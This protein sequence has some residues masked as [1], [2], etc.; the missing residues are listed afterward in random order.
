ML[1]PQTAQHELGGR[2]GS[3]PVSLAELRRSLACPSLLSDG[4][5]RRL[6]EL[7]QCLQRVQALGDEYDRVVLSEHAVA[8]LRD[9]AVSTA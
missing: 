9:Q 4:N 6:L 3:P 7:A 5:R 2:Q 8:A 1:I